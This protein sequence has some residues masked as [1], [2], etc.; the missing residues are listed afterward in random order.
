MLY[1]HSATI[2]QGIIIQINTHLAFADDFIHGST[3]VDS[4]SIGLSINCHTLRY[5]STDT[6]FSNFPPRYAC[7]VE[8]SSP[9]SQAADPPSF[10]ERKSN[11][12]HTP[13]SI[14][15]NLDN[16][17]DPQSFQCL[18][19]SNPTHGCQT[20]RQGRKAKRYIADIITN[21]RF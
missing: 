11:D 10:H 6:Y 7:S 1:I 19:P 15:S 13:R 5:P 17:N 8:N 3:A 20:V 16:S 14:S 12:Y 21:G 18:D 2:V 9:P 4:S